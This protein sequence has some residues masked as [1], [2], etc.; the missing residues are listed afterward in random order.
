MAA[1]LGTLISAI[2]RLAE[3]VAPVI[4]ESAGKI[5]D[6][7]DSGKDGAPIDQPVPL[8]PRLELEEE[9]A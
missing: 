2:R 3:A 8:F 4:P 9:A 6:L 7:I 1:V 5:I